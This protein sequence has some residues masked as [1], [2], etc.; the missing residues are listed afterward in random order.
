[1][2]GIDLIEIY[3][4]AGRKL[5]TEKGTSAQF[6]TADA[7]EYRCPKPCD[8]A[9][10]WWTSF[11][12]SKDDEV[13]LRMLRRAFESIKP[14][15]RFALDFMNVPGVLRYFK[16]QV[17]TYGKSETEGDI[18]LVRESHIDVPSGMLHKTWHYHLESGRHVTH[19]T[20]VRMYDPPAL[21]RLFETAGFENV[22][23]FGDLDT[24][25]M[26]NLESPRCIVAGQHPR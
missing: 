8:A 9:L 1:M 2:T 14:G 16:P 10:N 22:H 13:N 23:F 24:S 15:G 26:M 3:I 12:Y 19:E 5:A 11:G 18:L 20:S 7:F 25:K 4:S 6:E 17:V 21:R